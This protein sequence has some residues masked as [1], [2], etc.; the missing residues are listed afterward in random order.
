MKHY[1]KDGKKGRSVTP[2]GPGGPA[3]GAFEKNGRGI[4]RGPFRGLGGMTK[5]RMM[6]GPAFILPRISGGRVMSGKPVYGSG[7][8]VVPAKA[9]TGA[10]RNSEGNDSR[11]T[12]GEP[13]NPDGG[14]YLM[15]EWMLNWPG[16]SSLVS[17]M[18]A[19][20]LEYMQ[21][22]IKNAFGRERDNPPK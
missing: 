7:P 4:R 3:S 10:G 17:S 15:Q 2:D 22:A 5:G 21:R 13:R 18:I 1:P 8:D 19:N 14:P 11:G 9:T 12:G 20:T 6:S 16:L